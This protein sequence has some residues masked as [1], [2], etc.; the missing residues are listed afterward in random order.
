LHLVEFY[1]SIQRIRF[2]NGLTVSTNIAFL[3]LN[4]SVPSF[5]FKQLVET[6]MFHGIAKNPGIDGVS[7]MYRFNLAAH[8]MLSVGSS[9][10]RRLT[11]RTV[12]LSIGP[13]TENLCFFR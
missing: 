8:E 11:P 10:L 5:V 4:C 3:A 7:V 2:R 13:F 1:L 12:T 9:F 6:A